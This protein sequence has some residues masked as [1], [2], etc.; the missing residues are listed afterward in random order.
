MLPSATLINSQAARTT[1]SIFI[2]GFV[3]LLS[4]KPCLLHAETSAK[5]IRVYE[6]ESDLIDVSGDGKRILAI[7][8][9]KRKC[10]DK[11][12]ICRSETLVVYETSTGKKLGEFKTRDRDGG[13]FSSAAFLQ[14]NK[15]GAFEN[16]RSLWIEWNFENGQ[17]QE[18]EIFIKLDSQ[19]LCVTPDNRFLL[20][21]RVGPLERL[22]TLDP[23]NMFTESI[24]TPV[25]PI[26][27]FD[28]QGWRHG[29][30]YLLETE[31]ADNHVSL[32]LISSKPEISSKGCHII[33]KEQIYNH[34]VSPDDSIIAIITG[35]SGQG[36]V[37][38]DVFS[39]EDKTFLNLYDGA[40]CERSK[41]FEL[42]FPEHPKLKAPLLGACPRISKTIETL[43]G[44]NHK[45][46]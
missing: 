1:R 11:K 44:M 32:S 8:T 4:A 33:P 34:T 13:L 31:T 16:S 9:Q 19:M 24:Q 29:S 17:I 43:I 35:V 37:A 20:K 40:A 42:E 15:V 45:N 39:P 30:S 2:M 6:R 41:R 27:D 10:A 21:K 14:Q 18:K 5:L 26:E 25:L 3:L 23:E 7:E 28:C 38:D 12:N 36:L 46:M 22:S